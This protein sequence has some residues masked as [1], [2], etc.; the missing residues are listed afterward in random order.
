MTA[1]DL[2]PHRF[3]DDSGPIRFLPWEPREFGIEDEVE[4]S[5]SEGNPEG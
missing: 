1:L 2:V 3:A 4:D 5:L